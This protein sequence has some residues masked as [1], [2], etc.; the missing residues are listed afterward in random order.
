MEGVAVGNRVDLSDIDFEKLAALFKTNPKTANEQ[1]RAK[2]E[3]KARDM[4]EESRLAR[5][6]SISWRRW[7]PS[8]TAARSTR[9]SSSTPSRHSLQR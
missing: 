4:A 1:A 6:S 2:A 9:P 7:L 5:T 3:Q 8:T